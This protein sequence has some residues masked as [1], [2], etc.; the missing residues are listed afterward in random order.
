MVLGI[1]QQVLE[2]K[3]MAVERRVEQYC[4]VFDGNNRFWNKVDFHIG[5][6]SSITQQLSNLTS[7]DI[8]QD[9]EFI[10]G[11]KV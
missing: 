2:V 1:Q 5:H 10:S 7:S 9:N 6:L 8:I 4:P 3:I 11:S